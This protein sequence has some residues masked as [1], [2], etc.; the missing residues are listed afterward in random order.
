VV[1]WTCPDCAEGLPPDPF[2]RD[3]FDADLDRIPDE[4]DGVL[5]V[6]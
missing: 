2:V 1:S 5:E 4:V 6:R 3:E